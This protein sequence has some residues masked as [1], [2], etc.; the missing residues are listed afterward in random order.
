M[1]F[2]LCEICILGTKILT[3]SATTGGLS[4]IFKVISHL[5]VRVC[6]VPKLNPTLEVPKNLSLGDISRDKTVEVPIPI[7]IR[8]ETC[9]DN[10]RMR[11]TL[12]WTLESV[13]GNLSAELPGVIV[14][15]VEST[16]SRGKSNVE[17]GCDKTEISNYWLRWPRTNS[18][19]L[20]PGNYRWTLRMT[21]SI[22]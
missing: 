15:G 1:P 20:T 4:S 9:S 16:A 5:L 10:Q 12:A 22:Q 8:C 21:L 6:G 2:R 18:A 11:G 3:T 14:M 19:P 17:T 7:S 13:A